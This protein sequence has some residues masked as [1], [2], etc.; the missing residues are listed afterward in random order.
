METVPDRDQC[1]DELG[2]EEICVELRSEL[3]IGCPAW[4]KRDSEKY[5][6]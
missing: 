6:L 1:V 4:L 3:G 2:P 5:K